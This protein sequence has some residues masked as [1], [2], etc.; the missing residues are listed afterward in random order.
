MTPPNDPPRTK[1]V[2]VLVNAEEDSIISDIAH[3]QGISRSDVLRSSIRNYPRARPL[4]TAGTGT[5]RDA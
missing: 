2:T 3:E 1:R 5:K 4:P